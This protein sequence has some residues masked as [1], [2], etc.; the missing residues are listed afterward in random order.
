MLVENKYLELKKKKNAFHVIKN[1]N[2]LRNYFYANT[3]IC[4]NLLLSTFSMDLCI[5][6]CVHS[7]HET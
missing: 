3:Y 7:L 6:A 5:H 4:N 2:L 1:L